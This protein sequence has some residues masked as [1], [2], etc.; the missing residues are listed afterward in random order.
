[1]SGRITSVLASVLWITSASGL[2]FAQEQQAEHDP[3]DMSLEQLMRL[4]IDSVYGASGFKQE[5]SNVP[6]SITIVTA[7]EIKRH[8][9]RTL[10]DI[11]RNIPGMY[12]TSDRDTS[13]IGMR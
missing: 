11:L 7:E 5:V 4:D 3:M 10:S 2:L 9:Y 1:M 12:V 13:Y 8:G 6:A